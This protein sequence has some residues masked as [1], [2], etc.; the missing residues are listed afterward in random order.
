ND[1]WRQYD[2]WMDKD[3][4]V[5]IEEYEENLRFVAEWSAKNL[6][7]FTL[8][9]PFFLELDREEFFMKQVLARAAVCEKIARETGAQFISLQDELD[10]LCRSR[11]TLSFSPDRVHPFPVTHTAI[12][13][14][15]LRQWNF[16]FRFEER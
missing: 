8:I 15:L 7:G 14:Y 9:A 13:L 5:G 11:Y 3:M 10:R 2:R 6:K 1:V 12:A 4:A 16:K